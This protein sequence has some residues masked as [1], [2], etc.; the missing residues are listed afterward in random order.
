[1]N[2]NNLEKNV[3]YNHYLN[4]DSKHFNNCLS[5]SVG[6]KNNIRRRRKDADELN[7]EIQCQFLG[8]REIQ[9]VEHG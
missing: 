6:G 1:M 8:V 4:P 9:D 5:I 3:T 2:P 7:C